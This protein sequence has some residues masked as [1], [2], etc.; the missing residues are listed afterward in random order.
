MEYPREFSE[1]ACARVE[2]EIIKAQQ[3]LQSDL[4]SARD[5][6]SRISLG[7]SAERAFD[8]YVLRV[9]LTFAEQA[10]DLGRAGRWGVPRAREESEEFLRIFTIRAF[11]Q[12]GEDL[13]GR[14]LTSDPICQHSGE[15]LPDV[16]RRFRNRNQWLRYQAQLVG[17]ADFIFQERVVVRDGHPSSK[18]RA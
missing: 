15:I 2:L 18:K 11:S 8:R 7:P 16:M 5:F 13:D 3:Q 12:D 17:L 4:R 9:F 14:R 6:P 1:S 10:C